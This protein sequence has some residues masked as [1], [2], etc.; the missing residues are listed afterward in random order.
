MSQTDPE[1]LDYHVC[2]ND[3]NGNQQCTNIANDRTFQQVAKN[4]GAGLSVSGD[5]GSGVIYSTDQN[6]NKVQIGT[7]QH[8]VGPGT[9]R[10]GLQQD[11]GTELIVAGIGARVMD[12]GAG[13]IQ[14]VAGIFGRRAGT[15]AVEDAAAAAGN[16][17]RA[18]VNDV[19][20]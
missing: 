7:Y 17:F 19:L 15:A 3:Q 2:V 12:A 14:G 8:F 13:L 4:P 5:N 1:G 20:Q 18:G 9:E 10:G 11:F 6:G 16:A